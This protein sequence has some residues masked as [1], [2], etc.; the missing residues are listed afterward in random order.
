MIVNELCLSNASKT[1]QSDRNFTSVW[2]SLH[3]ILCNYDLV[4]QSVAVSRDELFV[5]VQNYFSWV[6]CKLVFSK[7][8]KVFINH[9]P[10][11]KFTLKW[12]FFFGRERRSSQASLGCASVHQDFEAVFCC[13]VWKIHLQQIRSWATKTKSNEVIY[14]VWVIWLDIHLIK[15][16]WSSTKGLSIYFNFGLC[17]KK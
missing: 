5:I 9:E 8:S 16:T 4:S 2:K 7:A 14:Y 3:L 12:L 17:T 11:K 13:K 1:D 15:A 6:E 10:D